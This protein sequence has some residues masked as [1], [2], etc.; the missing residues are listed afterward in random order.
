MLELETIVLRDER[1]VGS[2]ITSHTSHR[3]VESRLEDCRLKGE[4]YFA[5]FAFSALIFAQR[6]FADREILARTAADIVLLPLAPFELLVR[7]GEAETV[8][9]PFKTAMALLTA[10]NCRCSF[11]SSCFNA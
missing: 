3:T 7:R 10:V 1:D 11:D 6:A 4:T 8:P 9:P 2:S 5:F